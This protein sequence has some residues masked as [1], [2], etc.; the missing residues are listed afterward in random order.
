M[1]IRWAPLD[2]PATDAPAPSEELTMLENEIRALL[3]APADGDTAPHVDRLE[4]ALTSGYARALELE[5]ERLR[6]ERRIGE[7]AARLDTASDGGRE[8]AELAERRATAASQHARLR[9]LL[10]NLRDRA[11]AARVAASVQA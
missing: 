9:A 4:H 5:A 11:A 7:V 3:A 10:N 6:L 1:K 2:N 8:L